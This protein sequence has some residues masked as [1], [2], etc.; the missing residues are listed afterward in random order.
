MIEICIN[1]R[2][3]I[4]MITQI[5]RTC[6]VVCGSNQV[7]ERN[8]LHTVARG[9]NLAVNLETSSNALVIE[10]RQG[11]VVRPT[12]VQRGD[13]VIAAVRHRGH[14]AAHSK[15]RGPCCKENR[16]SERFAFVQ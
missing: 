15:G 10:G 4:N 11:A 7:T 8:L 6:F 9:A 3:R 5:T 1:P 13:V 14:L 16:S 12:V 2:R